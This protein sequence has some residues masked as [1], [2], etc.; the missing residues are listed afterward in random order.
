MFGSV[1]GG[2]AEKIAVKG[3][4]LQPIP[5]GWNFRDAAALYLTGPT[6]YAAMVVRANVQPGETDCAQKFV[7]RYG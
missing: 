1:Q 2:F 4:H 3:E 5:K 6:S 7:G